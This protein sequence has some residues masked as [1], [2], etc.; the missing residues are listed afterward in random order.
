MFW[1]GETNA[2]QS[3]VLVAA[4]FSAVLAVIVVSLRCVL[5]KKSHKVVT[6]LLLVLALFE[7]TLK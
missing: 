4:L 2:L 1:A 3:I 6:K 5:R 7:S